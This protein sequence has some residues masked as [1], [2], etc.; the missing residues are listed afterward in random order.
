MT[1][2][3]LPD[4]IVSDYEIAQRFGVSRST[5][6]HWKARYDDFP[7]AIGRIGAGRKAPRGVVAQTELRSWAEVRD[8]GVKT[9]R[10]ETE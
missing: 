4:E 3:A 9:G 5:V 7:K 6:A 2:S 1:R 10:M 8:W